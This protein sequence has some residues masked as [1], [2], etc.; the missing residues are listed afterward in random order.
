LD[1]LVIG[2]GELTEI[3]RAP[4]A[5]QIPNGSAVLVDYRVQ[6]QPSD[7]FAT[8]ANQIH[9]R[10][11]LFKDLV[12]VYGRL[13]RVNNRGGE[14]LILQNIS[15]KVLGADFS[16]R[17]TRAGAE[18]EIYDSNLAPFKS[19]RLFQSFSFEPSRDSSLSLNFDQNWTAFS[20]GGIRRASYNFIT[21]YRSHIT[22]HLS[23]EAEAGVRLD[24]GLGFDQ[25]QLV[26]RTGL[27]YS[28]G[29]LAVKLGY[30][31]QDQNF[32]GEIRQRQFF[33]L[34]ARRNL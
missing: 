24:R 3:R 27:E 26:G 9:F 30:E 4:G 16:W 1:Y 17:W 20:N 8:L 7:K 14:T 23:W 19:K 11:D 31:Y 2:H 34:R 5:S 6:T 21:R 32:L 33:F 28:R 13:H 12:G 22:R 10:V 29:K 15:A 18:Y 25:T